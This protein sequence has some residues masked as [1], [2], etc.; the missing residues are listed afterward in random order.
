MQMLASTLGAGPSHEQQAWSNTGSLFH[1]EVSNRFAGMGEHDSAPESD[2]DILLSPSLSPP[3]PTP[4][5]L[6]PPPPSSLSDDIADKKNRPM[7]NASNKKNCPMVDA[8][9]VSHKSSPPKIGS[10]IHNHHPT[11]PSPT[12]HPIATVQN[13]ERRKAVHEPALVTAL[14][15][16]LDN[17]EED[18]DDGREAPELVDSSDDENEEKQAQSEASEEE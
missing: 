11:P 9:I 4:P 12:P 14:G 6:T 13:L 18:P 16:E 15:Q 10:G 8:S 5:K 7:V 1:V 17:G 2:I 3:N